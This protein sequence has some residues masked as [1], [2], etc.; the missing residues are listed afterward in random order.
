VTA[1]A[2]KTFGIIGALAAFPRRLAAREVQRQKGRLRRGVTRKTTQLVFG[3][4]L[5]DRAG[6]AEIEARFEAER[7]AGRTPLSENGFLRLLGLMAVPEASTLTRQSLIDQSGLEPQEFDLLSLF[8]VFE[9]DSEPYS[10]RDL[11]L[12]R[13]YAGLIAGG[14]D[15]SAIAKSVHR[16]GPVASL[17]AQ[18]L[19]VGSADAIYARRGDG[20]AELDGQ[21]LLGIDHPDDAEVETFFAE[22]ETAEAEGR[23]DAAADFYQRCLG[24]DAGDS[25]AA[26]NRANC[27]RAAGRAT[28][29]VHDYHRAIKRDPG[30]AEAWFN[31]AGL[32]GERGH[33]DTARRHLEKAIAID[34]DYADAVFNLAKLEFDAG[35]LAAARRAWARYL[36]L[37]DHSEW[38]RTAARGIQFVDLELHQRSAG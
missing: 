32:L 6:H 11:I 31:L 18:S 12:S 29:A 14:A 1:V 30:F 36:E 5:L 21:M 24:I 17:T 35:N 4:T 33:A 10:F 23:F 7:R 9:H 26:F 34:S 2:G 16:F 19:H 22:A 25:V 27:L 20:F 13:K 28:E 15:W 38:A 37:D 3:R 8:D